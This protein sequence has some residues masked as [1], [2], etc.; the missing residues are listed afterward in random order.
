MRTQ[1]NTGF[2]GRR[3]PA[4]WLSGSLARRLMA[5][6]TVLGVLTLM[7]GA[8]LLLSQR[9]NAAP[10][11][12]TCASSPCSASLIQTALTSAPDGATITV[13][14]GIYQGI[15]TITKGVTLDGT[16]AG[17]PGT[18]A[19]RGAEAIIDAQGSANATISVNA[20][21]ATSPV[22]IDGLYITGSHYAGITA[23]G[24]SPSLNIQYNIITRNWNGIY[25]MNSAGGV[26]VQYNL[27]RDN[28]ANSAGHTG[29][30]FGGAPYCNGIFEGANIAQL[31]VANN[32]IDETYTGPA[33]I[34]TN[35]QRALSISP[36]VSVPV[37]IQ[38]NTI[39]GSTTLANLT[40][41]FEHNTYTGGLFA[42][43]LIGE[44][45]NYTIAHNTFSGLL[46][47]AVVTQQTSHFPAPNTNLTIAQNTVS[48]DVSL[49]FAGQVLNGADVA[50]FD[51]NYLAGTT[52]IASNTIN[53]FG[54]YN[55][56][57]GVTSV[58]A[59]RLR[60]SVGGSVQI[61]AN[62]FNG[63]SV[64]GTAT[65]GIQFDAGVL[66]ATL[67]TLGNGNTQSNGIHN[68]TDG[69]YDATGQT[70]PF[71]GGNCISGN[72]NYG[73]EAPAG[74]VDAGSNWW[75][76]PLGPGTGIGYGNPVTTSTV[77]ATLFLSTAPRSTC[78]GPVASNLQST[79]NPLPINTHFTITA[80]LDTSATSGAPVAMGYYILDGG[81]PVAMTAT[82]GTYGSSSSVTV[83][84]ASLTGYSATGTH[85][86]CVFGVDTFGQYGAV[87]LGQTSGANCFT[88]AVIIPTVN[89]TT[90]VTSSLN[91]ST[92][93][94]SVTFTIT[95]VSGTGTPS[96]TV[97]L[98]DNATTI[99]SGL[100]L[101]GSGVA[102]YTTSALAVGTHPMTA[103]YAGANTA[104]ANFQPSTSKPLNQVVNQPATVPSGSSNAYIRFAQSS[105]YYPTSDI[106]IDGKV[107]FTDVAACSVQSY[108]PISAGS[109]TF[110]V[111]SPSGGSTVI[112][113]TDSFTAGSYYTLAVVGNTSPSVTP[114]IVVFDD[115]NTIS[116]N[117]ATAR[118]YHL[119]DTL[120]PVQVKAGAIIMSP[121]LAYQSA[122]G[123]TSLAPGAVAFTAKPVS[124]PTI[125]DNVSA[126]ANQVYSVF[127]LC[128][129]K[130]VNAAAVGIP[131][132]LPQTGYNP[133]L[134]ALSMWSI[135]LMV[136][137]GLL[138]VT[139][140][141][142]F[143]SYAILARRRSL[144]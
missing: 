140:G 75:G 38:Y 28:T 67:E 64:G 114:A 74:S 101:N 107:V 97:D 88:L 128:A 82:S 69:V 136:L 91:P 133:H 73:F 103:D 90:T 58:H 108:Y 104:S 26:V 92:F 10:F 137:G 16:N 135:A 6:T 46:S 7:G 32:T 120:G 98:K 84:S 49:L 9:A 14:P 1:R 22:T 141:V 36:N 130:S 129:G 62:A 79:V 47:N 95:V 39:V 113:A 54:S 89:T 18:S 115:N 102:T 41:Y 50:T 20:G 86:I 55:G 31:T 126:S 122:T 94:Q 34:T 12:V 96:G 44:V 51:L 19:S 143:G 132:G 24:G 45:D 77:D 43:R 71:G 3:G 105:E 48:Q 134:S 40:G 144:V 125:T 52:T 118:V 111:L 29:A 110:T 106:T 87:S 5:L 8:S 56:V 78:L 59:V 142:G 81:A 60:S 72:S 138:L 61:Q 35:F 127:L 23:A 21:S 109:H 139:G 124:G 93:G 70:Y 33:D 37:Q 25:E 68:F 76:S 11:T 57:G 53:F 123:Y 66:A 117:Q 116:P 30:C 80:Q 13:G 2:P 85:T 27:I 63:G 42:L 121:S 83:S 119:A 4:L 99:A 65:S 131:S 112:T 15:I 17:I 100:T